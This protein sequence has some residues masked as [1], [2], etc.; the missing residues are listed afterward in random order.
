MP[1]AAA[2]TLAKPGNELI[3]GTWQLVQRA[4]PSNSSLPRAAAAAS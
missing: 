1:M 4:L 2:G 3:G